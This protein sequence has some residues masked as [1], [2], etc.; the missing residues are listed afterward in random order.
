MALKRGRITT[1]ATTSLVAIESG[2]SEN[3]FQ[4]KYGKHDSLIL[5]NADNVNVTVTVQLV[6]ATPTTL[7]L[8]KVII[9]PNVSLLLTEGLDFNNT[10]YSLQ[11]VTA[12]ASG[13]PDLYYHLD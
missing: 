1:N 13:T 6:D 11:I 3:F 5:T 7:I 4:N 8:H 10:T 9:P 12:A 2:I